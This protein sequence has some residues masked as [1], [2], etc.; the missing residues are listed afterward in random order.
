MNELQK[1]YD[2][3]VKEGLYTRT[4]EDFQRQ[5]LRPDY[6]QKVFDTVSQYELY[7]SDFESFLTTY[8]PDGITVSPEPEAQQDKQPEA[9]ERQILQGEEALI[10]ANNLQHQDFWSENSNFGDS[11]QDYNLDS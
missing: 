7:S 2:T 10:A 9:P 11:A 8:S 5:Y 3:L 6:Q 4:F 1:L